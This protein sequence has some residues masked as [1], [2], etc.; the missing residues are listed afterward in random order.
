MTTNTSMTIGWGRTA[1]AGPEDDYNAVAS[2]TGVASKGAGEVIRMTTEL[3][4]E[5]E[6]LA[7]FIPAGSVRGPQCFLTREEIADRL[8][9]E[10]SGG[11]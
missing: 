5:Q 1:A 9:Q 10:S 7:G 4:A 2:G 3:D 11:S 6:E 8:T